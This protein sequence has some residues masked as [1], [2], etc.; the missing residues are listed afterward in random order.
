MTNLTIIGAV[1]ELHHPGV[2]KTKRDLLTMRKE[3]EY[4]VIT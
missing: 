4:Q 3:A 2:M 1:M